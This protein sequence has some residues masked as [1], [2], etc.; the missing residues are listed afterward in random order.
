MKIT[1]TLTIRGTE[2]SIRRC[3]PSPLKPAPDAD[4]E[5]P[6]RYYVYAHVDAAGRIFYVGQGKGRR[7]WSKDRHP[8]WHRYVEKHLGGQLQVLVIQD[9]LS[10]EE[11]QEL[12]AHWIEQC[13]DCVVNWNGSKDDLQ[14]IERYNSLRDANRNLILQAKSTEKSG[15]EKAVEMYVRAIEAIKEYASISY[16]GGLVGQLLREEEEDLGKFGE[17][18]ALDR[19]TLCLVKLKRQGDAAKH[20]NSYFALY[21]R[22]MQRAAY[23][24]IAKRIAPSGLEKSAPDSSFGTATEKR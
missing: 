12:E 22:D 3:D 7:A 4:Q 17:I 20:V 11:S 16:R 9:N 23:Q 18:E 10:E 2:L 14:A 8:L 5:N 24:R 6:R 1:A 19:L 21:R 13:E 15:L